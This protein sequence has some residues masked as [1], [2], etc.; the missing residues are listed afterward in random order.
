MLTECV[1]SLYR[2]RPTLNDDKLVTSSTG[3]A[4]DAQRRATRGTLKSLGA[5]EQLDL[6]S[7]ELDA[8]QRL[9]LPIAPGARRMRIV[10]QYTDGKSGAVVAAVDVEG[11]AD[12]IIKVGSPLAL[13]SELYGYSTVMDRKLRTGVGGNALYGQGRNGLTITK[14]DGAAPPRWLA[15]LAYSYAG[16]PGSAT[17]PQSLDEV[18]RSASEHF[19]QRDTALAKLKQTLSTTVT[20]LH[21]DA[22]KQSRTLWQNFGQVLPPLLALRVAQG[23]K[24]SIAASITFAEGPNKAWLARD[25]AA[26]RAG[27]GFAEATAGSEHKTGQDAPRSPLLHLQRLSLHEL[28]GGPGDD[29]MAGAQL[30]H[31]RLGMRVQLDCPATY[32]KPDGSTPH[33]FTTLADEWHGQPWLRRGCRFDAAGKAI[34]L[35]ESSLLAKDMDAYLDHADADSGSVAWSARQLFLPSFQYRRGADW[36]PFEGAA[37]R[38]IDITFPTAVGAT[39]GDLNLKNVFF[40]GD[41]KTGWL[42]DFEHTRSDGAIA[43]DYAKL[44]VEIINHHLLPQV[45]A[46]CAIATGSSLDAPAALSVSFSQNAQ[47]LLHVVAD[48]LGTEPAEGAMPMFAAT[49]RVLSTLKDY[50]PA[51]LLPFVA[52]YHDTSPLGCLAFTLE[53]IAQVSRTALKSLKKVYKDKDAAAM[54]LQ[55]AVGAYAFA[56]KKF[57]KQ[58]RQQDERRALEGFATTCLRLGIPGLADAAAAAVPTGSEPAESRGIAPPTGAQQQHFLLHWLHV[59]QPA[60]TPTITSADRAQAIFETAISSEPPSPSA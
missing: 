43:Y 44:I 32:L 57:F 7:K 18:L 47:F 4:S 38:Y 39:H 49:K 20:A 30:R 5:P 1:T 50:N 16:P 2:A 26:F 27:A 56:S 45:R 17:A 51:I 54:D 31:P 59:A 3:L 23:E 48:C 60:S 40:T 46:I 10:R 33:N 24:T 34:G 37:L 15:L 9:I 11:E 13:Q 29:K 42:I 6:H 58:E 22:T 36:K 28:S 14:V 53:A 21:A 12:V 35:G 19:D 55:R 25:A 41:D 8:L 52:D